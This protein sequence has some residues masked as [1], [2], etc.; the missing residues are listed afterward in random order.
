MTQSSVESTVELWARELQAVKERFRP[1]FS[2]ERVA[3][4]AGYFNGLERGG[5]TGICQCCR[6]SAGVAS[7][8]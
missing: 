6:T 3:L 2:Q 8:P 5:N 4:S 7:T 1:L